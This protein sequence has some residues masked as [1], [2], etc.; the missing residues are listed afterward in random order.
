VA[1]RRLVW[2]LEVEYL[3]RYIPGGQIIVVPCHVCWAPANPTLNDLKIIP[4]IK[5]QGHLAASTA[6]TGNVF[7]FRKAIRHERSSL[8]VKEARRMPT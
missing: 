1:V 8:E 6:M 7:T 5:R 3:R 4:A 2:D